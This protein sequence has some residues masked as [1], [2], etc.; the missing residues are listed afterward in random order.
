M[1]LAGSYALMT[2]NNFPSDM[3]SYRAG[4]NWFVHEYAIRF[5]ADMTFNTNAY[6]T[7]GAWENV[8]RLQAQFA[9]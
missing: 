7:T 8:G 2:A 9:W 5:S 6:G 3:N 4:L 1:E